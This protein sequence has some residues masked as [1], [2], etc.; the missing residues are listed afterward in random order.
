MAIQT[1]CGHRDLKEGAQHIFNLPN[2]DEMWLCGRP[3]CEKKY[4]DVPI[5]G[6]VETEEEDLMAKK[7]APKASS[8]KKT[9]AR[10]AETKTQAPAPT[11]RPVASTVTVP[12][13]EFRGVDPSAPGLPPVAQPLTP[14]LLPDI[15][16]VRESYEHKPKEL[17][18]HTLIDGLCGNEEF[19][20]AVV[21]HASLQM[22]KKAIEE[23]QAE[24]KVT[25]I[26]H[27]GIAG[28]DAVAVGRFKVQIVHKSQPS[29]KKELL[30]VNGVTADQIEKSTVIT[31]V[32]YPLIDDMAK[33]K[34]R[35]PLSQVDQEPSQ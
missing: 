30:L 14:L 33:P 5:P 34:H 2:D 6:Y 4:N 29:L 13:E 10:A 26:A 35:K 23:A 7:T 9:P 15:S 8:K 20:R 18:D 28:V 11:P 24:L 16:M 22:Q 12:L 3:K 1:T 31:H 21:L 17:T 19:E 27:M 25:L 32:E